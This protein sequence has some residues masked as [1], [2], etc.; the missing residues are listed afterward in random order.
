MSLWVSFPALHYSLCKLIS[1]TVGQIKLESLETCWMVELVRKGLS[2]RSEIS[3]LRGKHCICL[4]GFVWPACP[5]NDRL[6]L[7]THVHIHQADPWSLHSISLG[8]SSISEAP[9]LGYVIVLL[10]GHQTGCQEDRR[11][12]IWGALR[13]DDSRAAASQHVKINFPKELS[14]NFQRTQ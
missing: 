4:C 14:T 9:H 6:H 1:F 12:N 10:S 13:H 11:K 3:P 2:D 8:N 5:L 7:Q